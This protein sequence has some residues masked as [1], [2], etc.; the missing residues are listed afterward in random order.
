MY[1]IRDMPSRNPHGQRAFVRAVGERDGPEEVQVE[2]CGLAEVQCSQSTSSSL[3][4]CPSRLFFAPVRPS[5]LYFVLVRQDVAASS[6]IQQLRRLVEKVVGAVR[7]EA[8]T[9]AFAY[10]RGAD[11]V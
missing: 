6:N 1:K 7:A 2:V 5:W 11:R 3:S 10:F 8:L 9:H 4:L